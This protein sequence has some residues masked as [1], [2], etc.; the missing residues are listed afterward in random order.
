MKRPWDGPYRSRPWI[1]R[2]PVLD[3]RAAGAAT[4]RHSG[5]SQG[6]GRHAWMVHPGLG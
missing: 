6:A 1:S 4:V 5:A 3:Q 2:P